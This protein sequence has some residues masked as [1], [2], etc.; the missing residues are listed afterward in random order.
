MRGGW[1]ESWAAYVA[2]LGRP[3]RQRR[4]V[5]TSFHGHGYRG[6]PRALFERMARQ[7]GWDPIWLT[8]SPRVA[9]HVSQHW[10]EH[11]VAL[12]GTAGYGRALG[13]AQAVVVSHGRDDICGLPLPRRAF[14]LQTYHG[15]PTKRGELWAVDDTPP[16]WWKRREI[17][18]RYGRFDAFLSTSPDVTTLFQRRFGLPRDRFWELGS[19]AMDTLTASGVTPTR[20]QAARA[21]LA[22]RLPGY[23]AGA[24]VVLYA[25][26]FRT[27]SPERFF[28]GLGPDAT[29]LRGMARRAFQG[30]PAY[31]PGRATRWLPFSDRDL[32]TLAAWLDREDALLL[33]RPHPSEVAAVQ[34]LL[35]QSPR[36]LLAGSDQI[37]EPDEVL[38]GVDA[39]VTDYSGIFLEGL[40]LDLSAVFIPYDREHYARGFAWPYDETTPGP[41]VATQ[42]AFL[43]ALSAARQEPAAHSGERRALRARFWAAQSEDAT[44]RVLERL[45]RALTR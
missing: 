2:A 15:L 16:S 42:A 44:G 31:A 4:V 12:A 14:V 27:R 21:A 37:E 36:I 10:G 25:P 13:E 17:A 41:K 11:R 35:D 26:T 1:P 7:E 30:L 40:L 3:M 43:A 39:V 38:Q 45:E 8:T 32:T 19:P 28:P 9:S 22:R 20:R 24:Y 33:L 18:F 6:S 5:L 29:G 34:A 23:K